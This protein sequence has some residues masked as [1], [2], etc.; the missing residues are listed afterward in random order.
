ML[1]LPHSARPHSLMM[2]MHLP[3]QVVV[4]AHQAHEYSHVKESSAAELLESA[5]DRA[6]AAATQQRGERRPR[7]VWE[8]MASDEISRNLDLAGPQVKLGTCDHATVVALACP[9]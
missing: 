2:C 5:E 9:S 1:S 8:R 6:W 4:A 3:T 7:D